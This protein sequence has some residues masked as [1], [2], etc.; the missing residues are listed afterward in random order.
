MMRKI[1]RIKKT[2]LIVVTVLALIGLTACFPDGP[3][4]NGGVSE[5]AGNNDEVKL[6]EFYDK[7]SE[8]QELLDTVADAIYRNW[9]D[10]IYNDKFGENI[11]LAIA[12]AMVDHSDDIDLI[13]ALDGE[14]VGL[15]KTVRDTKLS[16]EVKSVMTAYSDYYELVVN[17]SGSFNTYSADKE[18]LKKALSS[19]LKDLSFEL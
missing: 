16:A 1:K 13:K 9:Y 19:A 17:V 2:V 12:S 7:V 6:Q 8:S 18:M 5:D 10:T 3:F 11:D 15:Y 4:L 14:I